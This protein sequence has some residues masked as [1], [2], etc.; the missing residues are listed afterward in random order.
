MRRDAK[1]HP[2]LGFKD[3]QGS[4]ILTS[5]EGGGRGGEEEEEEKAC[6]NEAFS[7]GL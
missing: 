2:Q 7:F 5:K 4:R 6:M 1:G 3:S